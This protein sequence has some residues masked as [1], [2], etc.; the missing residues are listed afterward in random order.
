M[1]DPAAIDRATRDSS[2]RFSA[3]ARA[4]I[5]NL[6]FLAAMLAILRFAA[7]VIVFPWFIAVLAGATLLPLAFPARWDDAVSAAVWF[8]LAALAYFYLGQPLLAIVAGV[9]G[10]MNAGTAANRM[11]PDRARPARGP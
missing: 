5:V 6:L 1:S 2:D 11:M 3:R 9:F 10:V 7:G 8:A 4:A